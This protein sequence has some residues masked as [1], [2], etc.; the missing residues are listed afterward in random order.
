MCYA[1]IHSLDESYHPEEYASGGWNYRWLER[2]RT[3]DSDR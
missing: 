2:Y 3:S 1:T